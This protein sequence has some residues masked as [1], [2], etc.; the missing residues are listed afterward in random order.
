M[1][2]RSVFIAGA[3]GEGVQTVGDVVARAF[4]VHGY[5]VFANKEFESRIRG[6]RSSY[7][8]RIRETPLGAPCGTAD[9][10]LAINPDAAAYYQSDVREDGW[11]IAPETGDRVDVI[12]PFRDVAV[13]HGGKEIYAN[14]AA[15]GA[16]CAT[17]GLPLEP[18][19]AALRAA[20]ARYNDEIVASNVAVA[21]AGHRHA[22]AQVASRGVRQIP[23]R[24]ARYALANT[25]EA[26]A[27]AAAAA[28]CRFMAA[29]P[30]SPSTDIIT[31]L[32][33]HEDLGVF[34]EQ[35]EDEIAAVNMALGASAGGA[36]AMTATSGGG[37]ALM[38]ESVSL[39][40][41]IET[42]IVIVIAQRPGPATGLPTRTAQEDLL[43]AIRAGHGEFPRIVFAASDPQDAICKTKRAFDLADRYQTVA[44]LLTDQ[45]LADSLFSVDSPM[46]P[47]GPSSQ[48]APPSSI[49]AMYARYALTETGISPRL[50]IGQTEHPVILDSDEHDETGHLTEDLRFMRPAM[51]EKRLEKG[52]RLKRE[53]HPPQMNHCED[54]EA[55]LIGWGSTRG[56]IEEAVERLRATG[57]RVG[58]IHFGDLWPLPAFDFPEN[59]RYWTVEGNATGQLASLLTAEYRVPIEG[60][61]GRYDGLPLDA[62]TIVKEWS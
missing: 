49:P 9:V 31:Y 4:Q 23:A 22:G 36:R 15:A 32:A 51:V 8:L 13:E 30:M 24:T 26:I 53:M 61:I 40:G 62:E 59:A 2:D 50:Y 14:S 60:R 1:I 47:D 42:P 34:T 33:A 3:A 52:R 43:F 38:V 29:Y 56:A 19:T 21:A 10:L 27:I 5:A 44:I 18:L 57:H 12:V 11:I 16:L 55:A 20:F 46:F 7:R 45:F 25:H 17:L 6:G 48:S 58:S 28:G 35:A 39:A 41:M 37:F 54:A